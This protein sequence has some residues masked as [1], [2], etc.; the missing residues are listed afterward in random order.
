M[1]GEPNGDSGRSFVP[2]CREDSERL[3]V[4]LVNDYELIVRGLRNMLAGSHD[5]VDVVELDVDGDRDRI[6]DVALVDTFGHRRHALDRV[7]ELAAEPAI[8]V[9]AVYSSDTDDEHIALFLEHGARAVLSKS[10]SPLELTRGLLAVSRGEIVVSREV[11]RRSA[12]AWPGRMHGLTQRESEIM[13]CLV[14]GHS[15]REIADALA[16]SENTVKTHLKSVFQKLGVT[17]RTRAMARIIGDPSFRRS[18]TDVGVE[19]RE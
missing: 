15:N 2:R 16:V 3:R 9:V 11:G 6:V 12:G 7:A 8:G 4:A 18:A 10:V 5:L 13:V 1:D 17:S 19:R 14:A